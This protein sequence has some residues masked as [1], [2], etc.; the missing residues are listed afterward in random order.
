[1]LGEFAAHRLERSG[2]VLSEKSVFAPTTRIVWL[3][4]VIDADTGI[5]NLPSRAAAVFAAIWALPN[6][7]TTPALCSACLARFSDWRLLTRWLDRGLPQFISICSIVRVSTAAFCRFA[8]FLA[9]WVASLQ[10]GDV[11]RLPHRSA[12]RSAK[13]DTFLC[14]H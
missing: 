5:H 10:D 14:F 13:L 8:L 6:V 2:F 11:W 3:G 1:M 12:M 4:K 7:S 9:D